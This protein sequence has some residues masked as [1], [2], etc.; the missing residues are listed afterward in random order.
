MADK[1]DPTAEEARA[2][3]ESIGCGLYEAKRR[4]RRDKMK[5]E[6]EAIRLSQSRIEGRLDRLLTLV[7]A[8][9]TEGK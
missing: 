6:V 1:F 9:I 5:F 3:R 7:E 4:I 8:I 2:L